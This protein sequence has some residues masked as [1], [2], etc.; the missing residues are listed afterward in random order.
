MDERLCLNT[1]ED[2]KFSND[3]GCMNAEYYIPT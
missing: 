2:F 1:F 3:S